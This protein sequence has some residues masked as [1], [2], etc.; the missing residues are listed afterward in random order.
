MTEATSVVDV[1][2]SPAAPPV[3]A[4][5]PAAVLDVAGG[6]A[7]ED[8]G[9]AGGAAA[10]EDDA[11][12]GGA[13][14]A[15]PAVAPVAAMRASRSAAVSHVILVPAELTRGR[16]AQLMGITCQRSMRMGIDHQ[17]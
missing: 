11:G 16:A 12:G 10:A 6:G 5:L 4:L 3:P 2:G 7:E 17:E 15:A 8:V 13:A 9:G 1:W 14:D